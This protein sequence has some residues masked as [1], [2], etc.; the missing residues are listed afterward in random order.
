MITTV[1]LIKWQLAVYLCICFYLMM[2]VIAIGI[3]P[4]NFACRKIK[5]LYI[6]I[7]SY[8][9]IQFFIWLPLYDGIGYI[10][11][12]DAKHN[13]TPIWRFLWSPMA[14][15]AVIWL[16]IAHT[17]KSCTNYLYN[18]E[19]PRIM[20]SV[21]KKHMTEF[22]I[23]GIFSTLLCAAFFNMD[24]LPLIAFIDSIMGIVI[25]ITFLELV[26][27]RWKHNLLTLPSPTLGWFMG[28][29]LGAWLLSVI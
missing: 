9:A 4:A 10:H 23:G 14:A 17:V 27:S 1:L 8:L 2:L 5:I 18:T 26:L 21:R 7:I 15:T 3:R 25:S 6:A 11:L 12:V 13:P 22:V 28:T 16:Y 29:W 19:K 24:K 20:M